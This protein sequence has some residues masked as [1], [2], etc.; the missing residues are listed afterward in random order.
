MSIPPVDTTYLLDFLTAILNTPSPTGFAQAAVDRT[1]EALAAFPQLECTTTRKGA[2]LAAWPGERSDRPRA[3]TAHLDTLGAMV[4]E[5]KT[6]GRLKLTKI[7]GYAWNTVEGEGCTIFTAGGATVRGSLL[8]SKA[9]AHVHGA[10]VNDL[11]R[12]DDVMEVRLDARTT[13]ADAD[14]RAG[15]RGGR[16]RRLRPARGGAGRVRP[17]APPGR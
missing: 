13:T 14:P 12:E 9:S 3:L 11:K 6:N 17:L 4:K 5:I 2:L 16:F 10:E 7:G 1:R 15:D 8:L